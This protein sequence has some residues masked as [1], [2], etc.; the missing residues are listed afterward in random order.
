MSHWEYVEGACECGVE[1]NICR[2][3]AWIMPG[4]KSAQGHPGQRLIRCDWCR[5]NC[6]RQGACKAVKP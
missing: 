5:N 2:A 6:T 3:G 1:P 4:A